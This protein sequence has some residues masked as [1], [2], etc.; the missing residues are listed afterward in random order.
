MNGQKTDFFENAIQYVVNSPLFQEQGGEAALELS[1]PL[2]P[3]NKRIFNYAHRTEHRDYNETF[4][5]VIHAGGI[6]KRGSGVITEAGETYKLNVGFEKSDFYHQIQKLT[7]RDLP[8]E[9][10]HAGGNASLQGQ[11][12]DSGLIDE[13]HRGKDSIVYEKK[14]SVSGLWMENHTNEFFEGLIDIPDGYSIR[15]K[16]ILSSNWDWQGGEPYL[17]LDYAIGEGEWK[18][19][20]RAYIHNE[21]DVTLAPLN[22]KNSNYPY[23]TCRVHLC[24]PSQHLDGRKYRAQ[25]KLEPDS[26]GTTLHV[27]LFK[28]SGEESRLE[29]LP[30]PQGHYVLATV[31][32]PS[33]AEDDDSNAEASAYTTCPLINRYEDGDFPETYTLGNA[34]R[35][36]LY[37]PFPY[38][39][40]VFDLIAQKTGYTIGRNIFVENP[41]LG[42]L[43]LYNNFIEC[44]KR[45]S[46]IDG[47]MEIGFERETEWNLKNHVSDMKVAEFIQVLNLFGA[48]LFVDC[49]NKRIDMIP[50]KELISKPTGFD[51]DVQLSAPITFFPGYDSYELS[52]NAGESFAQDKLTDISKD[53]IVYYPK[54]QYCPSP[55]YNVIKET[56]QAGM[57][58]YGYFIYT[59]AEDMYMDS[60]TYTNGWVL[61]GLARNPM[62]DATEESQN[63]FSVES[64]LGPVF[65]ANPFFLV[66]SDKIWNQ[67]GHE[68]EINRLGDIHKRSM[69]YAE[70]AGI[71]AG[72]K[73]AAEEYPTLG[74]SFYRGIIDGMPSL[75]HD[76]YRVRDIQYQERI[77]NANIA[78]K[79]EG[80]NGLYQTFWKPFLDWLTRRARK[81]KIRIPVLPVADFMKLKTS[82]RVRINQQNYL[83]DT[84]QA[85]L[86]D[87]VTNIEIEAY[88]C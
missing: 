18:R 60:E 81:A 15:F 13:S 23:I 7:L 52:F 3:L 43:V 24:M 14:V 32:N 27:A 2:T 42:S 68:E 57:P 38:L 35:T 67:Q 80:E 4:D 55:R 71:F 65:S 28:D 45:K 62:T 79:W 77:P 56:Y 49:Q 17:S 44:K 78:L 87:K 74:L 1:F 36:N 50:V 11:S 76:I 8:F 51:L 19:V 12:T 83:I 73:E 61:D 75:E 29:N 37:C 66:N 48:A 25:A 5:V 85:D 10:V 59:T 40:Y 6:Q 64:P 58:G 46:P 63:T 30:Y 70:D 26:E 69:A 41:E 72:S 82:Y 88:T 53:L 31:Y 33:L 22:V 9:T 84:I 47:S 16:G 21:F 39:A 54:E 34:L 86:G 20:A